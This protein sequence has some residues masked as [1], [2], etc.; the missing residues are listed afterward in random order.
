MQAAVASQL[1]ALVQETSARTV[2]VSRLSWLAC[3]VKPLRD[4]Q[5]EL[6]ARYDAWF[7]AVTRTVEMDAAVVEQATVLR[8]FHGLKT[9]DA[10]IAASA[11]SL[12]DAILVTGDAAFARVPGLRTSV[13]ALPAA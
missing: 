4:G 10:L 5:A 2:A 13:I 3:R 6:L 9:P 7:A 12:D 8:A 11:L 1:A